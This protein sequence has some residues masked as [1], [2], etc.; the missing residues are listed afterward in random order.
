M[1]AKKRFR[2]NKEKRLFPVPN[3]PG[4]KHQ[5]KSVSL[6]VDGVFDLSMENDQLLP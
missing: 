3:Y 6:A 1:P 5:E 2:L 4:E